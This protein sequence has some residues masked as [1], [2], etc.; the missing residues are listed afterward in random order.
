MKRTPHLMLSVLILLS[1]CNKESDT[2]SGSQAKA[3]PSP[4]PTRKLQAFKPAPIPKVL[5]TVPPMSEEVVGTFSQQGLADTFKHAT[6]LSM[7]ETVTPV[8]GDFRVWDEKDYAGRKR[9]TYEAR[10][11][12]HPK[13]AAN[14][15]ADI[16]KA[17]KIERD[18]N[19]KLKMEEVVRTRHANN[20]GQVLNIGTK[21]IAIYDPYSPYTEF[22]FKLVFDPLSGNIIITSY[23]GTNDSPSERDKAE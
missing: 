14:L 23:R 5:D 12:A 7:P 4:S 20:K 10:F 22:H 17:W 1:S 6:G 8:S 21:V 11:H 13:S 18:R 2:S 3:P 15:L 9:S 16:E 19:P